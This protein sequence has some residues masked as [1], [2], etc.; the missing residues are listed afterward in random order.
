[1]LLH[2]EMFTRC[3]GLSGPAAAVS[4]AAVLM[5]TRTVDDGAAA[6]ACKAGP[7]LVWGKAAA[8]VDRQRGDG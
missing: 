3:K 2:K 7:C 5:D 6:F 8:V 1:M 4:F